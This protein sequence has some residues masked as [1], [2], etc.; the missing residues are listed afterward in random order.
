MVPARSRLALVARAY[1]MRRGEL[2]AQDDVHHLRGAVVEIEMSGRGLFNVDGDVREC[3]PGRFSL[4]PGGVAV[5][6]P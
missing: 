2:T 5:M 1:G 3:R 4:L 6:V